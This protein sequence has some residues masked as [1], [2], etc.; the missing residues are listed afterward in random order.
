LASANRRMR[1]L[2]FL[3]SPT[4]CICGL[5]SMRVTCTLHSP[6]LTWQWA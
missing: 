4:I 3:A 5:A 6:S 2:P 1:C